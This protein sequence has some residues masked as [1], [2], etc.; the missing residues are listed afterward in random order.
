MSPKGGPSRE[1][2]C[3]CAY[4]EGARGDKG[5]PGRVSRFVRAPIAVSVKMSFL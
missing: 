1:I 3:P 5:F 4:F 2:T